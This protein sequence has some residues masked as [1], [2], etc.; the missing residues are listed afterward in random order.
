MPLMLPSGQQASLQHNLPATPSPTLPG[1]AVTASSSANVKGSWNT[2]ISSLNYDAYGLSVGIF[3]D[4]GSAVETK[5]LYDIGIGGAGSEV[6]LI[7]N[8][9]NTGVAN[10]TGGGYANF[11]PLYVPKGTR[12]SARHQSN[13][14]SKGARI[15]I[16]AH[17]GYDHPPWKAFAGCEGIGVDTADSGG[18]TIVAGN[19][20]AAGSWTNIGP[21]LGRGYK[22][23]LPIVATGSD[24]T[25]SNLAGNLDFGYSSTAIHTFLFA[26]NN[27]ELVTFIMPNIPVLGEFASGTQMQMRMTM[28]GTADTDYEAALMGFY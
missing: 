14:A 25:M 12:I 8:L 11:F 21:T 24:T 17:G 22:A 5:N 19:S 10:I 28:S 20:G 7:S 1:T 13:V 3:N 15:A 6:P 23:M 26:V 18:T 4:S 9:L 16:F 27:T 2:L